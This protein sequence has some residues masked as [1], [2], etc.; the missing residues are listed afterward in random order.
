M[1]PHWVYFVSIRVEDGGVAAAG[2]ITKYHTFQPSGRC[3]FGEFSIS[4]YT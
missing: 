4:F 3:S 1:A 2:E